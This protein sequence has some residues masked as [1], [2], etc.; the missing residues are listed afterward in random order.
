MLSTYY[1]RRKG[2]GKN[3]VVQLNVWHLELTHDNLGSK[4][5]GI[6]YFSGSTVCPHSLSHKLRLAQFAPAA[7]FGRCSRFPAS[8]T[9]CGFCMRLRFH[10]HQCLFLACSEVSWPWNTASVLSFSSWPHN[11]G[12]FVSS[13]PVPGGRQVHC[14][15]WLPALAS[16]DMDSACWPRENTSQKTSPQWWR[17]VLS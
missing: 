14:Q 2:L 3:L 16:L 5:V 17:F 11:L 10:V 15:A 4:E 1:S 12:S 6:L 9:S 13:K 7:V 8:P